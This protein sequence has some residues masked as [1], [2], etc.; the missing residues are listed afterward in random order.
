MK[1]G[2]YPATV[3]GKLTIHGVTHEVKVP[4]T[5]EIKKDMVQGKAK[6]NIT[7]AEYNISIPS[8]VMSNIAKT[9]EITADVSLEKFNK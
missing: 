4:G 9:V 5:L 7:L 2:S 8:A 6:F 1:E 3:E